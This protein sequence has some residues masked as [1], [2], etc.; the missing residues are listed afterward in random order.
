MKSWLKVWAAAALAV[1][2][3]AGMSMASLAAQ[4]EDGFVPL[5]EGEMVGEQLPA[6]SLVFGAYAAVWVVLLIY[7]YSLWRR[8]VRAERE[9]SEV[10]A[11]LEARHR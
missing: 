6:T 3:A 10:T 8:V 4:G 11:R 7:V 9:L 5:A 2:L 1:V